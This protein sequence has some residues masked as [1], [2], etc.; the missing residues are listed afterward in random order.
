MLIATT[1][2][3]R[4]AAAVRC[5]R[6]RFEV[7]TTYLQWFSS[8]HYR[9]YL[10]FTDMFVALVMSRAAEASYSD[11]HG[12]TAE[13]MLVLIPSFA[14]RWHCQWIT[15]DVVAIVDD[16]DDDNNG[17]SDDALQRLPITRVLYIN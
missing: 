6:Q 17:D 3:D 4:P 7:L 15:D 16:D 1:T 10:V 8:Y 14:R 2:V 13:Q 11:V 5:N 9:A 12:P